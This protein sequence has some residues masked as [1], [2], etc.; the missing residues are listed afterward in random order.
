VGVTITPIST[1]RAAA[2]LGTCALA[3][4]ALE[5][6]AGAVEFEAGAVEFDVWGELD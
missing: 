6:E 5:F 4:G 2:C 3:A 1:Q